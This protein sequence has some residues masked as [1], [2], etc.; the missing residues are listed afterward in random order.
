[1]LEVINQLLLCE[2]DP[3]GVVGAGGPIDE[4]DSYALRVFAMLREGANAETIARYLDWVE[5]ENMKLSLHAERN[6]VIARRA[7]EIYSNQAVP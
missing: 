5:S 2:W 7:I 6:R 3:I 4:Y 1:M